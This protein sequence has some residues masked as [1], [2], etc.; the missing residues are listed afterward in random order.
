M[1]PHFGGNF[2]LNV[3][4]H[5]FAIKFQDTSKHPVTVYTGRAY[6]KQT[7]NLQTCDVNESNKNMTENL[8][9]LCS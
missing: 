6:Q 1:I 3:S 9:M 7:A 2:D 8:Y 5:P 4:F